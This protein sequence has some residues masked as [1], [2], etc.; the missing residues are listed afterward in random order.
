METNSQLIIGSLLFPGLDQMDFTGPFEILSRLPNTELVVL[1]KEK[2]PVRDERGLI[3]MAEKTLNECPPLDVLHIPGGPGQQALMNDES[4]LS[5]IRERSKQVKFV[6]SVC[7]GALICGAA[8]LL[9]GRQ[10][11]THW[12]SR[13]V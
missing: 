10:A 13:R 4:V 12:A 2:G 3:L 1:A 7:T 5:F 8:G 6:F 11:T 9:K